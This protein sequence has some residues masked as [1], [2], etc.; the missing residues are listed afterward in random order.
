MDPQTMIEA[1]GVSLVIA[2]FIVVA[3]AAVIFAVIKRKKGY[4]PENGIPK[5]VDEPERTEGST[6]KT[7]RRE[8]DQ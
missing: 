6:D 4:H 7:E 8:D 5:R 2:V 3:F 1:V